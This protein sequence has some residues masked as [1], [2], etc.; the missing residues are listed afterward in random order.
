MKKLLIIFTAF[1]AVA[2]FSN[3][4]HAQNFEGV[5]HYE[6]AE[7]AKMG[8]GNMP[9]MIKGQRNRVEFGMGQKT[10]AMILVPN[11][12]KMIVIIDEM[13]AYMEMNINH[14]IDTPEDM[15]KTEATNTG[16]SK[17]IAG[18]TCE[19]WNMKSDEGTFETCLAK[20]MGTFMMPGRDMMPEEPP[21]WAKTL[22][23]EGAIPLEVIEIKGNGSRI[24]KMKAKKIEEKTLSDD[25]FEVPEGYRNMSG[26]R[27]GMQNRN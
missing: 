25:L 20:G 24:V 3:Q 10:G 15:N 23:E 7:M 22:M 12:S 11:K 26:M 1:F 4:T 5:I 8:R 2:I 19:V 21:A 16:E 9:Y 13:N 14:A 6:S 18:K 27:Q 17:T